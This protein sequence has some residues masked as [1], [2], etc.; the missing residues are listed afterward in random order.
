MYDDPRHI[1]DNVIKIRVNDDQLDV[2]K[3]LARLNQ[4]QTATLAV[5]LMFEAIAQRMTQLTDIASA[6]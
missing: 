3:A 1:R 5:E 6:A 2:I 4:R